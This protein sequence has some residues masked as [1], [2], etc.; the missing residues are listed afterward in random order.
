[1]IKQIGIFTFFFTIFFVAI[2]SWLALKKETKTTYKN[3]FL[4]AVCCAIITLC[5]LAFIVY[6]F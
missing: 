5:F 1:M 2:A 6:L 4:Y 3:I